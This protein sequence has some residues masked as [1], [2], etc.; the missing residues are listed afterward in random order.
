MTSIEVFNRSRLT[1]FEAMVLRAQLCRTG[2]VIQM[3]SSCILH[4]SSMESSCRVI[5]ARAVQ[6][7]DKMTASK[8]I[9][10]KELE[11]CAWDRVAACYA[12]T[13]RVFIKVD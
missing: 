8:S 6:R 9:H 3:D 7:G 13:K 2:Y 10:V 5:G 11:P 1:S 12:M 4:L